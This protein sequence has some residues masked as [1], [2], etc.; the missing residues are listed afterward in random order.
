MRNES[1][2][3]LVH[4]LPGDR[5]SV[6][7]RLRADVPRK[8]HALPATIEASYASELKGHFALDRLRIEDRKKQGSWRTLFA[9]ARD[10]G[11]VASF[12]VNV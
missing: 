3:C 10:G 11:G 8:L 12:S 6:C 1:I 4:Q 2:D 5:H 7:Y 9:S